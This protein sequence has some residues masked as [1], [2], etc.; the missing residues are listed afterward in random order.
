MRAPYLTDLA[1]SKRLEHTEARSNAAFVEGRASYAPTSGAEWCDV[2][3]T[4]AMFD[5]VGSPATQTFG[6]GTL[7]VASD[8]TLYELERFFHQRGSEVYHEVSPLADPSILA[9]LTGRGYLPIEMSSVMHRP[10]AANADGAPPQTDVRARL[11]AP[12]EAALWADISA[13]GWG[14]TPELSAFMRDF[15]MVNARAR[16]VACFLAELEG[17]PIAAGAV[18]MHG[19]VALLAGA[20]TIP[21]WRA[22]GAQAALLRAR[23]QHAVARGCDIAMMGALPGST[24]QQNAERQGFFIAYTRVKWH[25][26]GLG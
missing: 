9:L 24:S 7:G 22:R 17:T 10:L 6:L 13:Q 11:I 26:P 19:G 3:G 4:H 1:L 14:E 25:L 12:D 16:G 20:S 18:A 23:L 15:G 8:A 21:Q 5:G 2:E